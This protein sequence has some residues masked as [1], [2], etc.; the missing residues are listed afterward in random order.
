MVES[1]A[2]G[3]SETD[4]RRPDRRVAD[5][6]KEGKKEGTKEAKEKEGEKERDSTLELFARSLRALADIARQ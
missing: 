2:G 1:I 6:R 4:R 5:G 3:A